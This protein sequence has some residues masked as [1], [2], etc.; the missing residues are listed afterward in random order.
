MKQHLINHVA[1]V[2]DRS[3]SMQD[4]VKEVEDV[5]ASQI[6]F[7]GKLSVEKGQ[8]TRVSV[9]LFDNTVECLWFDIDVLRVPSLKGLYAPR[10]MTA[11]IDATVTSQHDL[12][13]TFVKYGDHAFLTFVITDGEENR[14]SSS[15]SYLRSLLAKQ[16]DRWTVTA[17]VPHKQGRAY[18][19]AAGFAE[20]NIMIWEVDS[21][22]GLAEAGETMKAALSTY[23]SNRATGTRSSTTMFANQITAEAVTAA[24]LTPI[25]NYMVIPVSWDKDVQPWRMAMK[26]RKLPD[27]VPCIEIKPFIESTGRPYVLGTAFYRLEKSEKVDFSK[28]VVIVDRKTKQAFGGRAARTVIGLTDSSTRIKPQQASGQYDIYVK[29]TS[30]N[31]LLPQHSSVLV[32]G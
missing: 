20:G 32:I 18:A 22:T 11:L 14:S 13:S 2:I 19:L 25:S 26:T 29:S 28:E 7:L 17:M 6:E 5:F 10:G 3:S 30:L 24:K 27:G 16:D 4:R 21:V 8:E 31:R 23:T 9:Y 15:V 1:I 12:A